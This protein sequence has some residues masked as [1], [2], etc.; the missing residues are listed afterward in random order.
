[1]PN[2]ENQDPSGK[3]QSGATLA[4]TG[5]ESED[6]VLLAVE[7]YLRVNKKEEL[8]FAL[9]VKGEDGTYLVKLQ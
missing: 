8:E 4:V 6:E 3:V 5:A 1:M 7:N 2:I 9:P